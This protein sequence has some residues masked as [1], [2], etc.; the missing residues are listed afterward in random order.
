M[1]VS[2]QLLRSNR[3]LTKANPLSVA[4]F[5]SRADLKGGSNPQ[6]KPNNADYTHLRKVFDDQKY[7]N[8]FTKSFSENKT[9]N[10]S[11]PALFTSKRSGLFRNENLS[12]P[13]GLVDFSKNSL[14]EAKAL[15]SSMM[16]DVKVSEDGRL[17][18][19]KKLD[20][21][22]DI[23][24]RVIDVAEFIRVAHPSQKWINAAQQTHEIMFEYMNQ[25][26]T[27]VELYEHLRDI[28]SD[29]SLTKRFTEEEIQVGE[30]LKQDFE[31]SGIH[32]DPKTRHN[33]VAITQEISLLGSHFNNEIHNLKS[34]WCEI[35][36]EEFESIDDSLLKKEIYSYQS[37][38]PSAKRGVDTVQ[39][40]LAGHIPY[41]IL[42]SCSSEKVR[43][44]VWIALH[45][46]SDEQIATLNA[47][48]KYRATLAT[49]LGY[50]SF[51]HYQLEHKM[52]KNPENVVTFL[53]N[54]QK[55]L[56]EK[57]VMEEINKL[58]KYKDDYDEEKFK[59]SS[60]IDIIDD[61][62]PW[63]R[64]YLLEKVQQDSTE[65]VKSLK[66]INAYFSVGTIVAGLSELFKSIY[67]VE[68][69]AEPTL[70]GETWDQNQVR[71]VA[72]VDLSTKKKLGYLYLDFWSPKVLPSHFTIV[73]SRKL[74]TEINTETKE[75][76]RELV[77]L[78]E[79]EDYQLPVI[80]LICNFQKA[81]VTIG[82][83][84][85]IENEKP[86]LLSLNQVDTVFHE[87]GHAM[88]SMIGRTDLHNLSGTRCS[89]DFVELP[90]V[91]M[92]SFSKDPR[93]L[94]K[95]AKHYET[96]EPLPEELL[97][98]H[99]TQKVML[100]ECETYMQSKMAMLDQVLH[101]EEVV[102]MLAK[103]FNSFDSTPIYHKLESDLKVFADK[104]STWHGKFPHL[105]SYGA[106]YYSYLLDRAIAEKV[107][108]GLFAK[109]PWSREAGEKY[110]NSILK[111]GG[112][113]DPWVC[114]AE[115]L[116]IDELSKG[117]SRAMEIIGHDSL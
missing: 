6:S 69:V 29:T 105:F 111:W 75:K 78:D 115:A 33:F 10:S 40:P 3:F 81:E 92:E 35:T 67:N 49:M 95:I 63:D 107:W 14:R 110:K 55:S 103:D 64:D 62:K 76:M 60:A 4:N 9:L 116:E 74:N 53:T 32:M 96:D 70:K 90:S 11:I 54:L 17:T 45:N 42:T 59:N 84:A 28:L 113:R 13:N 87:M 36:P 30:Y 73:C 48:L 79:Q 2:P 43:R 31:R 37:K 98:Q 114:L 16:E 18:Y 72:V 97:S 41:S 12:T 38:S 85:G 22:S 101:N 58:Y 91:L 61:I 66:S 8:Q 52:A 5:R 19:I 27:N 77:Q 99:Q 50:K 25:L 15:V 44:R 65:E 47:F 94:C 88:H 109:D 93:V 56:R 117:D 57:G 102:A 26:N 106:V 108:N 20:Q 39:I 68:F 83:F 7:F 24:C 89:T 104:W 112:T 82:R 46:S 34:Y 51:S 21:L 1:R 100:D 86:T 23:L 71:K 80:S